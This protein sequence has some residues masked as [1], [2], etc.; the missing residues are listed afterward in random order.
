MPFKGF[1]LKGN[2]K[3]EVR[4]GYNLVNASALSQEAL[5]IGI[6]CDEDDYISDTTPT[7]DSRE[8]NYTNCN[9]KNIEL[10]AGEYTIA[11]LFKQ[12]ITNTNAGL[13]IWTDDNNLIFQAQIINKDIYVGNFSIDDK[14][15]IGINI[16]GYDGVF[17][18]MLLKGSYTTETLP[19]Y[20]QYGVSP[21]VEYPSSIQAMGDNG[22]INETVC[23]KNMWGFTEDHTQTKNG[24]TLTI[25]KAEQKVHIE[26]TSTRGTTF[27]ITDYCNLEV[28]KALLNKNIQLTLACTGTITKKRQQTHYTVFYYKCQNRTLLSCEKLHG[29]RKANYKQSNRRGNDR[30]KILYGTRYSNK[31]R[32]I[33]TTGRRSKSNRLCRTRRTKYNNAS[34]TRNGKRGR[35]L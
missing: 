34:T 10:E 16:K 24:V 28:F 9:W 21:S 5:N 19:T 32:H 2:Y 20:E 27:I 17:R 26:G 12:Q 35:L 15:K 30:C 29:R 11:L 18:I 7:S 25:N 23:N 22:T 14:K 13:H 31:C 3:Q 4:S 8:W 33:H 6:V 1:A